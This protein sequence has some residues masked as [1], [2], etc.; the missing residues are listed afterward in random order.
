MLD[1]LQFGVFGPLTVRRNGHVTEIPQAKHRIVLAALLLRA[2]RAVTQEEL[3]QHLWG[4]E[5]PLTA[6]KTLQGYIARL[7]KVLGPDAVVSRSSGYAIDVDSDR[8]DLGRFERLLAQA[9]GAGDAGERARLFRAALDETG[10]IPL[11][12]IPSE[13]LQQGDGAAL[14]ER[15]LNAT[16]HWADAEM[17]VGRHAEVLPRLKALVSEHPFRESALSRLM[18]ALYGAGR[19]ADALATYQEARQL[20][21]RE[22]GVD[23][24][25]ELRGAHQH[26]LGGLQGGQQRPERDV[27]E[28]AR[29]GPAHSAPLFSLPPSLAE[30][31][32]PRLEADI[33]RR[34]LQDPAPA[35]GPR[36]QPAGPHPKTLTLHGGAGVGKT[37]M[38]VRVAHA[39]S[40][41]FPDGRLYVELEGDAGP[42]AAGDV[43]R[44]LVCALGVQPAAVPEEP[45]SLLALYRGLLAHRRILIVLDGAA[46]EAQVRPLL[47]SSDTCAALVTSVAMLP[48]LG[49]TEHV[50]LGLLNP[51]EAADILGRMIGPERVRAEPEAAR[52]LIERCGALPLAVRIVGARLLERP[53]WQLA[54]MSERLRLEA[55]RLDELTVGELSVRDSLALSYR[56]VGG[57]ERRAFRLLSLLEMPSFPVRVAAAALGLPA[58]RTEECL[59]WLTARHLLEADFVAGSGVRYSFHPLVRLYARERTFD[60][61]SVHSRHETVRNALRAWY[62]SPA[63]PPAPART[64]PP[65]LGPTLLGNPA[66]P[67]AL[68]TV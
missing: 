30:F 61:D 41:H 33:V 48:T 68:S 32:R 28:P 4:D 1:D 7:R 46:N 19:Q 65:G 12:D 27:S 54:Q 58:D 45:A 40:E 10:G 59:E 21:D 37:T 67:V 57:P 52:E 35:S 5:P 31:A 43:L 23:P 24:G 18:K 11:V 14:L 38:A 44:E 55:R 6:R 20:L 22:L 2:N 25:E 39:V 56:G 26:I 13:N 16:E 63:R 15:W 3:I 50:R 29:T 42:R 17:A 8:L 51:A 49:G 9:H 36:P 47:P 66:P 34:L 60:E 64:T 62:D 53:H